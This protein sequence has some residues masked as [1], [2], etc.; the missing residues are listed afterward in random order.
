MASM[1]RQSDHSPSSANSNPRHSSPRLRRPRT[2]VGLSRWWLSSVTQQL[3]RFSCL[4]AACG[5]AALYTRLRSHLLNVSNSTGPAHSGLASVWMY[6]LEYT[7]PGPVV[8]FAHQITHSFD[9]AEPEAWGDIS[10]QDRERLPSC[11][12]AYLISPHPHTDT[13]A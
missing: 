6:R 8:E 11:H 3:P 4:E 9:A 7:G 10:G 12:E 1:E 13:L 5:R 2:W